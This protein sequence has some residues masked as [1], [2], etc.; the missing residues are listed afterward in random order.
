MSDPM[1]FTQTY[2]SGTEYTWYI[3]IEGTVPDDQNITGYIWHCLD[4]PAN[5]T[6]EGHKEYWINDIRHRYDGPAITYD[7]N[8]YHTDE[9]YIH[10]KEIDGYEYM[11]WLEEQGMNI[12]NLTDT[13]KIL[14]DI[15]WRDDAR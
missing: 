4:G 7:E 13:D 5:F 11:D 9:W 1:L 10:D 15:R 2:G 14:I 8:S 6:T 12:N 3:P